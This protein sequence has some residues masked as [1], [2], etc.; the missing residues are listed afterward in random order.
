M[1]VDT[2]IE[3]DRFPDSGETV[4][5]PSPNT[6]KTVAGGKGCNQAVAISK[7]GGA[8]CS[9]VGNF[10]NDLH[11]SMLRSVLEGHGVDVSACGENSPDLPS[12]QGLVFLKRDGTIASVVIGGAN[13]VWPE[14]KTKGAKTKGGGLAAA[15]EAVTSRRVCAVLLQREVPEHVNEA[16]AAAAHAAG[17]PVLQDI[18]GEDRPISDAQLS[19]CDF[20]S[21]NLTELRRLTGGAFSSDA[22]F[23]DDAAVLQAAKALQARGARNVL[24]T[25]GERGCLLLREGGAALREACCPLPA[26]AVDE[27]GAGDCFRAAFAVALTEQLAKAEEKIPAEGNSGDS[28]AAGV[29]SLEDEALRESLR[30]ASAAGA[31]AVTRLGAVPAIPSRAEVLELHRAAE[32]P[33]EAGAGAGVGAKGALAVRGGCGAYGEVGGAEEGCP[34]RFAS[35]LNSMKDRPELWD[36][37]A[38]GV[39][40][41]V[42]RQAIVQG[43]DLVDF[44][45]PQHLVPLG[46]EA[47]AEAAQEAAQEAA[48][49]A[50]KDGRL[51]VGEAKKLLGELGLECGAVCLRYPNKFRAG[52]LTNPDALLRREAVELTVAAGRAAEALG[53]KE[54]VVWSAFDGYDYSLQVDYEAMW[55][56]VVAAFQEVC[57][58][59]PGLKVSLEFKPTDENMRFFCVP[60]TGAALLLCDDVNRDNFGLTMDLGHCLAAGENPA[61]SVAMVG[62]RGKLF[63]VQLNDGYQRIGAEDGL[64]FGSVHPHMAQ[65]LCLWLVKTRF[66]GHIYFD[67]FPRNEDPVA[68]A[69]RN[70]R[71]AKK[72]WLKATQL[73]ASQKLRD[74]WET[75]DGIAALDLAENGPKAPGSEGEVM[76]GVFDT[77]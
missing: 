57:D 61:Q 68:E 63:G 37:D 69:E 53:A 33:R 32:A 1:N 60:S 66:A 50:Q 70:I 49:G 64:L 56:R 40:G 30:F 13:A 44:N 9:F 75:H 3:V 18:G 6:G 16:V 24:V 74:C 26:A 55:S 46:G 15:V 39:A 27:T 48:G 2:I 41:W 72:F 58:A 11:A 10:G 52:A 23:D 8:G 14:A 19:H 28:G 35:R 22:D 67:T 65:E 59:C 12:G 45:F 38:A 34:W 25:L 76:G 42:M 29:A 73:L 71:T 62:L 20:V 31:L 4:T 47:E 54:L 7:L 77:E 51:T 36:G 43:L 21:P 5:T 17:I